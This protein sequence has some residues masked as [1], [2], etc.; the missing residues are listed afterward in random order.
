MR[1]V[2][3]GA[4]ALALIA[5]PALA[6][7]DMR[8]RM[9]RMVGPAATSAAAPP[10]FTALGGTSNFTGA[11]LASVSLSPS[12]TIPI[13]NVA[14]LD[15]YDGNQ[16]TA[17]LITGTSVTD[18]KSNTWV[19]V[20]SQS[21]GSGGCCNVQ[22]WESKITTPILMSDSVTYHAATGFGIATLGVSL[23]MTT[24]G[25][26][27]AVDAA[28]TNQG[29]GFSGTWTISAAG[30]GA[31]S[32]E[33]NFAAISTNAAPST[34]TS[35]GWTVLSPIVANQMFMAAQVNPGTSPLTYAGTVASTAWAEAI[36]AIKP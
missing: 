19:L 8:A 27:C 32:A 31:V 33:V 4:L 18:S 34:P 12:A 17:G 6:Q 9:D 29:N 24:C 30:S 13:G 21:E 35:S 10:P 26:S 22:L 23:A 14:V 2:F 16:S 28:V 3:F 15:A 11:P 7:T 5:S 25:I 20:T 1:R 36:I